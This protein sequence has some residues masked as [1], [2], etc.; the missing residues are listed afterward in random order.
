[1]QTFDANVTPSP[2][3]DDRGQAAKFWQHDPGPTGSL[4]CAISEAVE[5]ATTHEGYRYVLGSR[6]RIRCC[7]TSPSSDLE[8][9]GQLWTNAAIEYPDIVIGCAGGGSNLGGLIAPFMQDKLL[10]KAEADYR[11]SSRS[12]RRPARRFTRGQVSFTIS[13]IP[14]MLRR[15]PS[16]YT[17]GSG[18]MPVAQP[19]RRPAL[20][21]HES[22]PLQAVPR[23]LYGGGFRQADRR[24]RRGSSV[25]Q[26]GDHSSRRRSPATPS[27]PQSTKR[28]SARRPARQRP[29]CSV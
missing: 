28:S 21:R 20:P 12:S 1:M 16:M 27:A 9:K 6:A 19:R 18:F 26:G 15:W 22:D 2:S 17:L 29:S 14:A 13:A 7:C 24:I 5:V 4:G 8:S 10:G 23:R 3:N 11:A 25:R